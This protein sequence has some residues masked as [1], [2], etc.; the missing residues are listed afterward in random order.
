MTVGIGRIRKSL[1]FSTTVDSSQCARGDTS[2]TSSDDTPGAM[3]SHELTV[4][5]MAL[6]VPSICDVAVSLP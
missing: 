2:W 5:R 4:P 6:A 1:P 3:P